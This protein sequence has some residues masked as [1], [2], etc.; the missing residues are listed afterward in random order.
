MS[1]AEYNIEIMGLMGDTYWF[2]VNDAVYGMS[3]EYKMLDLDG[4]PFT[5][6]DLTGDLFEIYLLLKTLIENKV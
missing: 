1:E 2:D 6:E 5:E 4:L 3:L